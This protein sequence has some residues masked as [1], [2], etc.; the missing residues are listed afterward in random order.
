MYLAQI[1]RKYLGWC[2]GADAQVRK[3]AVLPDEITTSSSGGGALPAH[4][5][6]WWSRYRNRL[7]FWALF[8]LAFPLFFL[9]LYLPAQGNYVPFFIAGIFIASLVFLLNVRRLW[10]LYDNVLERG[11]TEEPAPRQHMVAYLV[12]SAV[13]LM[14]C[15]E[16][17]V[18]LEFIPGM[19]FLV[20]PAFLSGFSIIPWF[21]FWL[22]VVWE[23]G[24]GCRLFLNEKGLYV[25]RRDQG[26]HR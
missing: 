1:F 23:S 21:A 7:L 24:S 20:L 22:I 2:P 19:D 6:S 15:F 18:F 10:R 9:P 5:S 16:L 3:T 11:C 26:A 14:I 13:I 8:Y 12:V 17:L 25:R 4:A